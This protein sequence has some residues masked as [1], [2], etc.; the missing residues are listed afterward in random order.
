M[1]EAA[2]GGGG[3]ASG[4]G[5]RSDP[6]APGNSSDTRDGAIVGSG[7]GTEGAGGL[8]I[9]FAGRGSGGCIVTEGVIGAVGAEPTIGSAG[10]SGVFAVSSDFCGRATVGTG[11]A[12]CAGGTLVD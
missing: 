10:T 11:T 5:G 3:A 2:F 4:G 12:G 6:S 1:E 9:V 7:G 8:G